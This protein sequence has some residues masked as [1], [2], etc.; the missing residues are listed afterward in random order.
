MMRE[1]Q[2]RSRS[3]LQLQLVTM[4]HEACIDG[5]GTGRC[6]FM[7]NHTC[8]VSCLMQCIVQSVRGG[9]WHVVSSQVPRS[10]TIQRERRLPSRLQCIFFGGTSGGSNHE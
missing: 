4:K 7:Y 3:K 9:T 6:D 8:R 10:T 1:Y 2:D 5:I